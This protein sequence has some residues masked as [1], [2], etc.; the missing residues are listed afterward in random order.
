MLIIGG[1]PLSSAL[2]VTETFHGVKFLSRVAVACRSQTELTLF[3]AVSV[4][5]KNSDF[6]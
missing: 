5:W 6:L 3:V 2:P 1:T 4:T